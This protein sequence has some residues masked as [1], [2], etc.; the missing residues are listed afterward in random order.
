[1]LLDY[2]DRSEL[3]AYESACERWAYF[4]KAFV[5]QKLV[6]L[7]EFQDDHRLCELETGNFSIDVFHLLCIFLFYLLFLLHKICSPDHLANFTKKKR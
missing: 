3:F 1:M 6:I 2:L 5:R 7:N 4:V